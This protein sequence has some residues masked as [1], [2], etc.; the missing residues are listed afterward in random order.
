MAARDGRCLVSRWAMVVG[1][2]RRGRR[3]SL[4]THPLSLSHTHPN[5]ATHHQRPTKASLSHATT[6][7][8]THTHTPQGFLLYP[9][10]LV[11]PM[12][13]ELD[14]ERLRNPVPVGILMLTVLGVRGGSGV[15]ATV[16]GGG[17]A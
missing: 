12:I 16:E 4:T 13:E 5:P 2:R 15:V 9:A 17:Q 3:L 14:L 1:G 11:I 6:T 7:T 10:Q 8:T